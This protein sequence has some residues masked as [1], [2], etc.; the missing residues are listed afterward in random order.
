MAC[1]WMYSDQELTT[2]FLEFNPVD[3]L[4]S[5]F[6]VKNSRCVTFSHFIPR[7]ELFFGWPALR[8]VMGSRR[9]DEVLRKLSPAVHVFGHS[10]MDVD[11]VHQGVRYVQ[12]HLGSEPY[13]RTN[14]SFPR[15]K[16]KLVLD[17]EEK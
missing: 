8:E 1:R 17:A 14:S 2:K 15:F 4:V 5:R 7:D 11:R 9:I 6:D 16:P 3:E 10:H 13:H 12:H